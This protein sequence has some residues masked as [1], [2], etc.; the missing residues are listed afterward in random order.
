MITKIDTG[1]TTGIERNLDELNRVVIP[2][3][4][5]K[6]Q[7]PKSKKLSIYPLKNGVYI[8]FDK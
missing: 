4:I 8:E 1:N 2:I 5:L 3:E 6:Q 7:A